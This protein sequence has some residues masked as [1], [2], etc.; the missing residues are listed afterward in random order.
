MNR[1]YF[2]GLALSTAAAPALAK[3]PAERPRVLSLHHMHTDERISVVYRIGDRYQRSGLNKLNHFLR[4]FRTGDTVNID[5]RL[6]DVLH[7]IQR[8]LGDPD[9]RYEVLSAY[10]SPAT[11]AMLRR[12]GHGVARNSLHLSGQA[13]DIR[14]PDLPSSYV[15]DAALAVNLGGVGYYPSANF[16]HVDTGKV[17]RWGA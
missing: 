1:R 10:R 17:R 16:V 4:D 15:R 13:M 5:P 7:G 6:F 12:T 2:L 8:H 14:F 3:V 11:N 9:A